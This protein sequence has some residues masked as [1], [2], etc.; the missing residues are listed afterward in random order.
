MRIHAPSKD[1]VHR[2]A[3][4]LLSAVAWAGPAF[5]GTV[6]DVTVRAS[7]MRITQAELVHA[8]PELGFTRTSLHVDLGFGPATAG[9]L[10]HRADKDSD[11]P[12]GNPEDAIMLTAGYDWLLSSR[13]RLESFARVGVWGENDPSQPLYAQDT[14]LRLNLVAFSPDGVTLWRDRAVH[15]SGYVGTQ[16]NRYGRVQALA[17]AGAWWNGWGVYATAHHSFNGVEDLSNAG[18]HFE[19]RFAFLDNRGVTASLSYD[20]RPLQISVR[21]HFSLKNGGNDLTVSAQWS[22]AFDR[23]GER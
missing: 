5:G 16:I 23:W 20:V 19:H 1:T 10:F 18:E 13:V 11:V 9:V 21:R 8:S 4:V 12:H 15:P 6:D 14:D 17:G 7:V 22:W 2:I 3:L